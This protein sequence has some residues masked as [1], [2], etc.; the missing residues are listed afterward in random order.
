[1]KIHC[2]DVCDVVLGGV[3]RRG[4][5][6]RGEERRGEERGGNIRGKLW[7]GQRKEERQTEALTFLQQIMK[8]S[9]YF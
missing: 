2:L 8:D 4:V 7:Q 6:R 9:V 3:E 5:A 1:M